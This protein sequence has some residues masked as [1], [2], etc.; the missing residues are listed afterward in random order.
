MLIAACS[1]EAAR[2][3]YA[4]TLLTSVSSG[5]AG[6]GVRGNRATATAD[7][8]FT[9]KN[10]AALTATGNTVVLGFAFR[11]ATLAGA[12]IVYALTSS[13][14]AVFLLHC[15]SAGTLNLKNSGGT[16]LA[17]S[18]SGVLVANTFCF[19]EIKFTYLASG[20]TAFTVK[21]NGTSVITY[22]A[23]YV[24]NTVTNF[25]PT[26]SPGS[27]MD[28]HCLDSTGSLNND[29]LGDCRVEH[30]TAT[31]EGA[32]TGWTNTG[33]ANKTSSVTSPTDGDTS[34]VGIGTANTRQ[35][36]VVTDPVIATGTVKSV[37]ILARSHG[38]TNGSQKLAG[39]VRTGSGNYDSTDY[40]LASNAA[41]TY[42]PCLGTF[43]NNPATSAAWT[44]AEVNA[45]EAGVVVLP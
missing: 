7:W 42:N 38:E 8:V 26:S 2:D 5:T 11:Q 40:G 3:G 45:M 36:F 34:Y 28:I 23:A 20:T 21:A 33:G 39:T 12:N 16:I 44:I 35:T 25:S 22:S 37:Q 41:S 1:I 32:N 31:A 18:S 29:F 27:M 24:T 6:S 17:S 14:S 43:E 30:L 19:I 15:D 13:A 4:G 10:N 9:P